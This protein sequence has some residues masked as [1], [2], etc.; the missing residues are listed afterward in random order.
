MLVDQLNGFE[1]HLN[2]QIHTAYENDPQNIN[3]YLPVASSGYHEPHEQYPSSAQYN[4]SQSQGP[5]T[6]YPQPNTLQ[7]YD[8]PATPYGYSQDYTRTLQYPEPVQNQHWSAERQYPSV[9]TFSGETVPAY[10]YSNP[11]QP[12]VL[13]ADQHRLQNTWS[14]FVYTVGSPPPFAME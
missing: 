9:E 13:A 2:A 7:T 1:G 4:N 8:F 6:Q 5:P 14:S 10:P 11:Q 3:P 12:P